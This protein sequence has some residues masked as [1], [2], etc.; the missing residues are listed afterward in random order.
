MEPAHLDRTALGGL[1]PAVLSSVTT[2]PI[3]ARLNFAFNNNVH[4]VLAEGGAGSPGK[5]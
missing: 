4:A 1:L 2:H 3:T 5:P